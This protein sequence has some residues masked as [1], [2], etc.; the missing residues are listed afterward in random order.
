MAKKQDET[1]KKSE[2]SEDNAK[3]TAKR[4]R[5]RSRKTD[6]EVKATVQETSD[7]K[8]EQD[9]ANGL[10]EDQENINVSRDFDDKMA[11]EDFSDDHDLDEFSVDPEDDD[12]SDEI[13]EDEIEARKE[14]A[15]AIMA[16]IGRM[17]KDAIDI[18][19]YIAVPAGDVQ[20]AQDALESEGLEQPLS[21]KEYW[22]QRREERNKQRHQA[23]SGGHGSESA[24][25]R[26]SKNRGA[27]TEDNDLP[28]LNIA[29][30]QALEV[31]TLFKIAEEH[32]ITETLPSLGKHDL[33]FAILRNH[34]ILGGAV[35]AEGY[36]ELNQ[37]GQG[38][39]RN[40][41]GCF[42][43]CPEDAMVPHQVVRRY[44]L[45]PGDYVV[46]KTRPPVRDRRDRDFTAT[47]VVSVNGMDFDEARRLPTFDEMKSKHPDRRFN[48]E[49]K[50]GCKTAR[51]LD[52][53]SPIGFGQRGL[54]I[55]PART[56]RTM[57]LRQVAN[58]ISENHPDVEI[59]ML[60]I[61]ERPE[62]ITSMQQ[63]S[64]AKVFYS[65]FDEAA[66]KHI[67]MAEVVSEIARRKAERGKDVV[68][69]LDSLSRL[70]RAYSAVHAATAKSGG[71]NVDLNAFTKTKRIFS[72]ARSFEDGGS[73]TILATLLSENTNLVDASIAEELDGAA[74]MEIYL[75]KQLAHK[76]IF[77]AINIE[78]TFTLNAEFI[79]G[80]EEGEL[81]RM[82]RSELTASG[83]PQEG[84]ETLLNKIQQYK[85]NDALLKAMKKKK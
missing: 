63:G 54:I 27:A 75:D 18:D 5:G 4:T 35:V 38:W 3:T 41:Y 39:L 34:A 6:D 14:A 16:D 73:V 21:R 45:R 23:T 67:Q 78:S 33:V 48:L 46:A 76:R 9:S 69:M 7:E 72:S 42:K 2:K 80:E 82:L 64:N 11:D 37:L 8:V 50:D 53:I 77:P 68:V 84:M 58:A 1:M 74:N 30:L 62:E 36:L 85:T 51:V 44:N 32:G 65:T 19:S 25:R 24:G 55:A 79:V 71:E 40:E 17:K 47:E 49:T 20:T 61:G 70:A 81:A 13:D 29:E 83:N 43:S 26:N 15:R 28:S 57:L 66:E 12:D 56:G 59:V 22:N 10:S 60:L 31:S 52:L